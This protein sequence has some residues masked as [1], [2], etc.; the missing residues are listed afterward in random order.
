MN[1]NKKGKN[2]TK[3]KLLLAMAP[4]AFIL[5]FFL[6]LI[7]VFIAPIAGFLDGIYDTSDSSKRT[8]TS[9]IVKLEEEW[10]NKGVQLDKELILA[11]ILYGRG[12]DYSGDYAFECD[13]DDIDSCITDNN[14]K[15]NNNGKL[16]KYVREIAKGMVK[17][18][19]V[20]KCR[21][22]KEKTVTV[23]DDEVS[24]HTQNRLQP[25]SY[26]LQLVP[27]I[28]EGG[29][30][31]ENCHKETQ[32]E[33]GEWK[34]CGQEKSSCDTICDAGYKDDTE[35]IHLLKTEEEFRTWLKETGKDEFGDEG[36]NLSAK[37][38]EVNI[39]ITGTEE[40]KEAKLDEIIDRIYDTY[41]LAKN[42]GDNYFQDILDPY[43]GDYS[44]W[45]QG[46]PAWGNQ[47]L[48]NA[49]DSTIGNYGCLVT[50][51]AMQIARSGTY[52]NME[53][54]GSS[55]FNPGTFVGRIRQHGAFTYGGSYYW[56]NEGTKQ[57]VPNFH[58]LGQEKLT[59]SWEHKI[60]QVYSHLEQ[61]HYLI[62]AVNDYGHWVA[63]TGISGNNI[64]IIDPGGYRNTGNVMVSPRYSKVGVSGI[65]IFEKTD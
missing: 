54:L 59:G 31:P 37:L 30:L 57:L 45:K 35:T 15:I 42:R 34:R 56:G 5:L 65:A 64:T 22:N 18:E 49:P 14:D 60:S 51:L 24:F 50:S 26:L 10:S 28:P 25:Y 27:V 6:L 33:Y 19:T 61:G 11:V 8:F 4:V 47:P 36:Y 41:T 20:Y 62:L 17:E 55:S 58:Y 43:S 63:V 52:I 46:D 9:E 21:N 2:S 32:I 7:V 12:Y 16:I 53:F 23:C 38:K 1:Q 3:V 39:N 40:E 13:S 48:G 29:V 44:K